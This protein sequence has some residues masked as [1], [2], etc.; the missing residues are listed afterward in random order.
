MVERTT[1]R[2][3]LLYLPAGR[4]AYLAGQAVR[5]AIIA[6]PAGLARGWPQAQVVMVRALPDPDLVE[7]RAVNRG[8]L[9]V[10]DP[11]GDEHGR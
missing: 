6:R 5:Q 1:R 3:L 7:Q 11:G 9:V 4:D 10:P 8:L 2:V